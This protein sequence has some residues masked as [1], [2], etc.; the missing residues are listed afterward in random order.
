[1]VDRSSSPSA[2]IAVVR[3]ALTCLLVSACGF[4]ANTGTGGAPADGAI[5]VAVVD[6]PGGSDAADA[7]DA[8]IDGPAQPQCMA[9]G[10]MDMFQSNTPCSPWATFDST[11]G[12]QTTQSGG[13]LRIAGPTAATGS[14]HG[15]CIK[16]GLSAWGPLGVFI[17]VDQTLSG[18]YTALTAYVASGTPGTIVVENGSI[19][20]REPGGM[21]VAS[22]VYAPTAMRWWRLRPVTNGVIGETSADAVTWNM[23]GRVPGPPPTMIRID[24]SAGTNGVVANAGTAVFDNLNVCP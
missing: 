20:L 15:G 9:S 1:M 22:A 11:G 8:A 4:T 6:A 10:T 14:T 18:G 3:R 16:I 5:D 2:R 19:I 13:K 23:L 17:S 7:T 12:T 24:I 21:D